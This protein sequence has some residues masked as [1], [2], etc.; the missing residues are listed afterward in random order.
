MKNA[1][2]IL[3]FKNSISTNFVYINEYLEVI[4]VLFYTSLNNI[5]ITKSD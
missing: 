3:T 2:L 5:E 4:N 1:L